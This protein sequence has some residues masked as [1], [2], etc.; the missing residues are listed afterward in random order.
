MIEFDQRLEFAQV[1]GV[2]ERM[3]QIEVAIRLEAVMHDDAADQVS[4]NV[5]AL[6]RHPI[7][8]QRLG[9]DGVQ[10]MAA[11]CD[12]EA[13][14]VEATHRRGR[15]LR[16]KAGQSRRENDGPPNATAPEASGDRQHQAGERGFRFRQGPAPPAIHP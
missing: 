7:E 2:A 15:S 3:T 16:R 12:T 9:G 1:M 14:L 6:R 4:G 13:G 8:G 10:P 11:A 5:A